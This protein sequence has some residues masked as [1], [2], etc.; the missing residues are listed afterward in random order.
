MWNYE[1]IKPELNTLNRLLIQ[2]TITGC[3]VMI[4][5]KLAEV[6]LPIPDECIMHDWWI[7][8][9]ASRFGKID[10]V[11]DSTIQYRQHT[12]NSIGAKGFS[13]VNILKK[14]FSIFLNR[15]LYI[16]HLAVNIK[17][18]RAFLAIYKERLDNDT[19][20]MLEDFI[21]IENK[22]FWQKRKILL[23]H[24]LLKHGFIRN[25]GLFLKI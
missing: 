18:A 7:G 6:S 15:N 24:K 19:I 22:S 8:L 1:Y 4:N 21:M 25:V 20:E 16:K 10:Y 5:K 13:Y 17:Q 9:V 12:G 11:S 14:G 2:N 23:K 3:T